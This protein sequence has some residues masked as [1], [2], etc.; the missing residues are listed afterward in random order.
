MATSQR[1]GFS[2]DANARVDPAQHV[3]INGSAPPFPFETDTFAGTVC[4]DLRGLPTTRPQIF[5]GNKRR[6]FHVVIQG[7]FRRRVAASSLCI[8]QE[9]VKPGNAPPWIGELVLSAAARSFSA[10]TRVDA[11]APLPYFMNPLLAACQLA[12][13]SREGEEPRDPW[14]AE[15]DLKLWAPELA[16]APAEQ[17]RRWCDAPANLAGRAFDPADGLVWT[18]HVYQ[19]LVDFANYRLDLAGVLPR[20]LLP[21]FVGGA[22]GVDLAPAL[23]CQPLQ[24]TVKDVDAPPPSAAG[25]GGGCAYALSLLVWHERLLF[26]DE[27]ARAE[28]AAAASSAS[29]SPGFFLR[30]S[31]SARVAAAPGGL[32]AAGGRGLF[33]TKRRPGTAGEPAAAAAASSRSAPDLLLAGLRRERGEAAATSAEADEDPGGA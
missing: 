12:N 25:G 11:R 13:A 24:L 9:F 15:E 21:R 2:N 7:R 29:A 27:V 28:G 30:R 26:P 23:D 3:P 19:H 14:A 22:A 6:L 16:T 31:A 33:S 1:C 8:G 5:S 17:R 20:G 32:M 18:F 10:S 4:V